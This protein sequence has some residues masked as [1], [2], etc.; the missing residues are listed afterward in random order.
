MPLAAGDS[1]QGWLKNRCQVL[2]GT[3]RTSRMM[4]SKK[5][6]GWLLQ[7]SRHASWPSGGPASPLR[8]LAC[9]KLKPKQLATRWRQTTMSADGGS[10]QFSLRSFS[11]L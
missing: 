2:H 8:L 9:V 4:T 10:R 5:V 1:I 11:Q 6:V 7:Q 3:H